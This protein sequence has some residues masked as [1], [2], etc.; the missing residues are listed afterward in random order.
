MGNLIYF[1]GDE[2]ELSL[3]LGIEVVRQTLVHF[4]VIDQ[5]GSLRKADTCSTLRMKGWPSLGVTATWSVTELGTRTGQLSTEDGMFHLNLRRC[6]MLL[7]FH[8]GTGGG[9]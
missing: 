2:G 3:R 4:L 9:G 8:G 6:L 5:M 1:C 7:C